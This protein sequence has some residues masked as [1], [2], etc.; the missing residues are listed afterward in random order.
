M[1]KTIPLWLMA[2]LLLFTACRGKEPHSSPPPRPMVTVVS[3]V[4]ISPSRI[5]SFYE[6]SGTVKAE[7]T[8][9]VAARTMGTVTAVK[10]REGDPVRAGQALVTLDDRGPAEKV[11]QAEAAHQEAL[12]AL[13]AAEQNKSLASVT[14][15][16]YRNLYADKVIT[17]QEMDQIETQ[18]K[19]AE[20]EYGRLQEMVKRTAATVEEAKVYRGFSRVTAPVSGVVTE[21]KIDPGNLALPGM[22]LLTIENTSQFKVEAYVDEHLATKIKTGTKVF[23]SLEDSGERIP[24]IVGEVNPAIDPGSRTYR[25]KIP[26]KKSGLKS[27]LYCKVFIPE[28]QEETILVPKKSVVERGQLSGVYVV[29]D[30]RVMIFRLIRTG[31]TYADKV[32]VLS[33]LKG[34]ELIVLEGIERAV[35]GG[36]VKQ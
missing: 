18:K 5:D 36:M 31:K 15:G 24:G 12:K 27:G 22:P 16:R 25:I 35:D 9:V 21:K 32:E 23:I 34:A 29:D 4:R 19:V 28:G 17:Q 13:E 30:H 33:G 20:A 3:L 1:K 26:L 14:F 6:A 8:S 7:T 10:V 2:L 11:V